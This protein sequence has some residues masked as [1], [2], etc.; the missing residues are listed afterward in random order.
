MPPA[1]SPTGSSV[2]VMGMP[3]LWRT[4]RLRVLISIVAMSILAAAGFCGLALNA[5]A[6]QSPTPPPRPQAQQTQKPAAK[7]PAKSPQATTTPKQTPQQQLAAKLDG[8]GPSQIGTSTIAPYAF[9]VDAQTSTV[10][11][12]KDA[13][14][15]MAPSS[16]AKMMT[17]YLMRSEE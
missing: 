7:P 17:A 15:P 8:A 11:L 9:M 10:L 1:L 16:M 4:D 6:Q 3:V 5:D 13:D 12:F 14:K 2:Q